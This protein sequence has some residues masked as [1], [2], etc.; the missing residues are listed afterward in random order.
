[1]T[2][3]LQPD[4]HDPDLD[5]LS[6]V[7]AGDVES[8][9]VLVERYEARLFR[10]CERMLQSREEARDAA[11]EVFLK[12]FRKAGSYRPRGKV[13]TWLYRIAVNHCLNVL[14]RRKL[15]RFLSFGELG[16]PTDAED[17]AG[18]DFEPEAGEPD[19]EQRLEAR[20]RWRATRELIDQL[21]AGQR[22]V[23]VL[24]KFEGLSYR[25][26]AEVLEISEGAVE[27]RLFRAMQRLR[28]AQET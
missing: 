24:A 5:L 18:P 13:Y 25:R 27:S 4:D 21:P 7:A 17:D 28:E 14:R 8:F 23:L 19:P 12:A 11:Q 26:I 22:A 3:H 9:G 20:R 6:R 2:D 16:G 10:L 1:M 15:V